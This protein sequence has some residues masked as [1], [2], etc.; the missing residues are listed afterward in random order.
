MVLEKKL[1]KD[2]KLSMVVFTLETDNSSV[3]PSW[4]VISSMKSI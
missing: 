2:V 4:M 1:I 3:R